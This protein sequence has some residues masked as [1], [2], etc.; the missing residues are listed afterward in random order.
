MIKKLVLI[1]AALVVLAA[2]CFEPAFYKSIIFP[3]RGSVSFLHG[4]HYM[5]PVIVMAVL[6]LILFKFLVIIAG[7]LITGLLVTAVVFLLA[8]DIT[9]PLFTMGIK[10]WFSRLI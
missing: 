4:I 1:I 3:L 5:I 9:A 10:E 7:G 6:C 8:C 2:F